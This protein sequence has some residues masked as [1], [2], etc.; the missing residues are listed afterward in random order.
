MG[1]FN[2]FKKKNPVNLI[3]LQR[4][5]EILNDCAELIESTKNPQVFF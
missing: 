1:L 2:L 5:L 4:D 3:A